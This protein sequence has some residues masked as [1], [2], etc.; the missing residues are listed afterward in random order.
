MIEIIIIF[1][2]GLIS[3]FGLFWGGDILVNGTVETAKFLRVP[4]HLIAVTIVALGT[5]SPELAVSINA[6]LSQ[7]PDIA[8]GNVVGSNIANLLLVLGGALL[9]A[10]LKDDSKSLKIDVFWMT[11]ATV[12]VFI[13]GF[14]YNGIN[15]KVGIFLVLTLVCILIFM[16]L[17]SEKK[18]LPINT[19]IKKNKFFLTPFQFSLIKISFGIII[20]LISS[21]FLIKSAT[22]LASFYKIDESLIGVTIVAL[23]TSL[24]EIS[25]SISATRKGYTDIAIG[26]VL[27]SNLFNCLGILGASA[28]ASYPL[29]L[30]T[31]EAFISFDLPIMLVLTLFIGGILFYFKRINRIV[32]PFLVVAYIIYI[33]FG[34]I[35]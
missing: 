29:R 2:I 34:Y 4:P 24:P 18:N 3:L 9:F 16:A 28:L 6:V 15:L 7:S 21:E 32:G 17:S 10:S 20:I 27:G 5:S 26:N 19:N 13:F 12:L 33:I 25:A 22:E 8:W 31:P 14:Y 23:G 11:L 35:Q 30:D 1:L